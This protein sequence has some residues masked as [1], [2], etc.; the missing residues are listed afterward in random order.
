MFWQ[1]L[2]LV[3]T[4]AIALFRVISM[5]VRTEVEAY[6]PLEAYEQL[7]G[8]TA[9]EFNV[10]VCLPKLFDTK[11]LRLSELLQVWQNGL[12][13]ALLFAKAMGEDHHCEALHDHFLESMVAQPLGEEAAGDAA[14]LAATLDAAERTV[15]VP[16]RLSRKRTAAG[17]NSD[18]DDEHPKKQRGG[19]MMPCLDTVEC[20]ECSKEI[21]VAGIYAHW[22]K[23]H[24]AR[25]PLPEQVRR[26]ANEYRRLQSRGAFCHLFCLI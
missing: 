6:S 26:K 2:H 18:D 14:P 24:K 19:R 25:G 23:M 21:S 1:V 13:I 22:G 16:A 17:R 12:K 7:M 4:N 10:S 9:E 11:L 5:R 20:P 15:Q 8:T 3:P